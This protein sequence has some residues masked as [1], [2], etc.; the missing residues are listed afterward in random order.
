MMNMAS[1]N[2]SFEFKPFQYHPLP[3]QSSIHLLSIKSSPA[4]RNAAPTIGN[5]PQLDLHLETFELA[6]AP[7]F[8]ALSYSWVTI[9][10][11]ARGSEKMSATRP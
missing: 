8:T 5:V 4:I 1:T 11:P 9:G 2:D 6:E 7:D 3:S 10:G